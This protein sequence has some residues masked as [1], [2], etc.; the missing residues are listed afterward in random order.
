MKNGL[1][2]NGQQIIRRSQFLS[3]CLPETNTLDLYSISKTPFTA[4]KNN[5]MQAIRETVGSSVKKAVELVEF[6]KNE[7]KKVHI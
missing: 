7:S 6:S 2:I 4:S 5:I 3:T 1:A